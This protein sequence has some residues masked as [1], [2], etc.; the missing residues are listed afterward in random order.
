MKDR[1]IMEASF[2]AKCTRD[3]KVPAIIVFLLVL[4]FHT[5][6]QGQFIV[7]ADIGYG[8]W[9]G[10]RQIPKHTRTSFRYD[11]HIMWKSASRFAP[12][13]TLSY[14]RIPSNR[15]YPLPGFPSRLLM[16]NRTSAALLSLVY[17]VIEWPN[18]RLLN[19]GL[20]I[21]LS[22]VRTDP[23]PSNNYEFEYEEIKP[24][25]GK[26]SQVLPCIS[27]DLNYTIPVF[28]GGGIFLVLSAGLEYFPQERDYSGTFLAYAGMA[29][30]I[31]FESS[32]TRLRPYIKT[33]LS[34]ELS[35]GRQR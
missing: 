35:P 32:F 21:G 14:T 15:S 4:S 17:N 10:D 16:N 8:R 27:L 18:D 2:I 11:A 34:I 9:V 23:F 19:A 1:N 31:L 22:Y 29:D 3:G 13:L 6:S 26:A 7:G 5:R 33:G 30:P 25:T 20:G 12:E 28:P 24:I